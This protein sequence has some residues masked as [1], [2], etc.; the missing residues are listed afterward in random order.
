MNLLK[1]LT[2]L[3]VLAVAAVVIVYLMGQF[4]ATQ[5]Y[6]DQIMSYVGQAQTYVMNN[7]P[8]VTGGI[9]TLVTIGGVAASKLS[10][11]KTQLNTVTS[12]VKEA[13]GQVTDLKTKL[14]STE[15]ALTDKDAIIA[16]LTE[17]NKAVTTLQSTVESQAAALKK[18]QLSAELQTQQNV[19]N[20][21]N[22]LPGDTI[23]LDPKTGNLIKTVTKVEVK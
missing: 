14:T 2:V 13:S 17:E 23:I 16:K 21:T 6:H 1:V 10:A 19:A 11:A 20:F 7:L 8:L 4:Q 22:S 9:G 18:A 15:Q 5:P 3:L 12:Q